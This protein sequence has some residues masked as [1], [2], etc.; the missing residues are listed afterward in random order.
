MAIM[1]VLNLSPLIYVLDTGAMIPY[2]ILTTLVFLHR[3]FNCVCV[4]FLLVEIGDFPEGTP[5]RPLT[6]VPSYK[7]TAVKPLGQSPKS[8]PTAS[9]VQQ[10]PTSVASGS[11]A[12]SSPRLSHQ[13]KS[14]N[15]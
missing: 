6:P 14:I 4:W 9:S 1:T 5:P 10:A 13:R 7:S 15:V 12:A 3:I 8:S 2:Y 11:V